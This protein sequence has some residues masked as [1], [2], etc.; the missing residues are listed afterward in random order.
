M[1]LEVKAASAR[2]RCCWGWAPRSRRASSKPAARSGPIRVHPRALPLS[3]GE[4]QRKAISSALIE[5]VGFM[6]IGWLGIEDTVGLSFTEPT[7]SPNFAALE[8]PS[9]SVTVRVISVFPN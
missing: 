6:G 3:P 8:N 7:V 9:V 5:A 1:E 4:A 2:P